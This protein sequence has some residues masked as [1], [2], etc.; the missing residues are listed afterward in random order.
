MEDAL[1]IRDYV[2]LYLFIMIML[3]RRIN[4]RQKE[5]VTYPYGMFLCQANTRRGNFILKV[6]MMRS[7]NLSSSHQDQMTAIAATGQ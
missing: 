7:I 4:R 1:D 2:L 3:E 5:T 6:I